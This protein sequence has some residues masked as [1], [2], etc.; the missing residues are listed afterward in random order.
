MAYEDM[1]EEQ[2]A[3]AWE[4]DPCFVGACHRCTGRPPCKC[5]HTAWEA[6]DAEEREVLREYLDYG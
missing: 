4:C 1:T 6:R 3:E 2:V 5:P